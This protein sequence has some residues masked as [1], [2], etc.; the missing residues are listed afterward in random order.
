MTRMRPTRGFTLIELLVAIAVM[1]LLALVSWQGLEGMARAQSINRE[2]SDAVLTLQTALSQWTA[3]LDATV[4][5]AQTRAMD[6]DGRT[7]RL[8]RRSTDSALPVVYVVAWTLRSDAA[9]VARWYRWQSPGL[10]GR[11]EWQQAWDRAAAWGQDS[12]SSD[13]VGGTE[14]ALMPLEAWQ[15]FY[16]RN[17]VWG[18]A[19]GATALGT[20]T[21]LPDGVR[22]VLSLPPGPALA[23]VLTRDWV[24]PTASAPKSS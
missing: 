2:R 15:L 17:D 6:W 21:P 23:G 7:L 12:T 18:P 3:D 4:T 5:L 24:R 9:G 10:T 22:L 20:G 16:F 11:P 19:V 14:I 8:T 1:A 13:E